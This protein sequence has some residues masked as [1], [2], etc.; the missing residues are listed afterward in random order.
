MLPIKNALLMPGTSP[1]TG[2]ASAVSASNPHHARTKRVCTRWGIACTARRT[3]PIRFSGITWVDPVVRLPLP[4][5]P[6]PMTTVPLS[7]CFNDSRPDA[8][9]ITVRITGSIRSVTASWL[10]RVLIGIRT[11]NQFNISS[12]HTPPASTKRRAR[13]TSPR[14]M[15]A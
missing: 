7:N 6:P 3:L 11:A 8:M 12:N 5:H 1:I 13:T 2:M 10:T 9:P 15:T 14:P 4:C